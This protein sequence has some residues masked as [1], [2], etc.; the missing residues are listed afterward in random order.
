M[1]SNEVGTTLEHPE[2]FNG[3]VKNLSKSWPSP[4]LSFSTLPFNIT[5]FDVPCTK[6]VKLKKIQ[7]VSRQNTCT[8]GRF[9]LTWMS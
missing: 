5:N 6:L 1:N 7:F 3:N 2:T 4:N 8:L 9:V